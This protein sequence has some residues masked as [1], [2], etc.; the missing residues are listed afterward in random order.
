[1]PID[2]KRTKMNEE[3][4]SSMCVWWKTRQMPEFICLFSSYIYDIAMGMQAVWTFSS[5][6][7]YCGMN[8]GREP[9]IITSIW[10]SYPLT[11]ILCSTI[12]E[13]MD[14]DIVCTAGSHRILFGCC[15]FWYTCYGRA[16]VC[17]GVC[18]D[19]GVPWHGNRGKKGERRKGH[20]EMRPYTWWV[21]HSLYEK[22]Y[23]CEFEL[24]SLF[25][26]SCHFFVVVGIS[27]PVPIRVDAYGS[28]VV[29][30][31]RYDEAHLSDKKKWK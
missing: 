10:N 14:Y 30:P 16:S 7:L 8:D 12:W 2:A 3:T 23:R 22:I 13:S 11:H 28:L 15:L 25:F 29:W 21:L 1:M 31:R 20:R 4:S 18:R 6:N 5:F 26:S 19:R 9:D 17:F 24:A 27:S